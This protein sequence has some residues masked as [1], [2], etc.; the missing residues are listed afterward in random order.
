MSKIKSIM[1]QGTGSSVG[2]SL[3]A[4]ALCRILNNKG[5][6][7]MPYKSQ[8]MALNSYITADGKEMGRAQVTQAVPRSP[9]QNVPEWSRTCC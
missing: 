9:R 8:N 3:L 6:R 2:K 7:V 1:F 5:M 4:A